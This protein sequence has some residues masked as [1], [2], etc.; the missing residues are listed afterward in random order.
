M[1][2][3]ILSTD[4]DITEFT[5][6]ERIKVQLVNLELKQSSWLKQEQ[7]EFMIFNN[8]QC[9]QK[10]QFKNAGKKKF[11]INLSYLNTS[12]ECQVNYAYNWF[13]GA[14]LMLVIAVVL[15]ISDIRDN[16]N[17]QIFS[18]SLAL[19]NLSGSLTALLI[20]WKKS[21]HRLIFYSHY[22]KA[23]ILEFIHAS[24]DKKAFRTFIEVLTD[25][26]SLANKPHDND[27]KGYLL[28]ELDELRRLK[29]ESV[30]GSTEFNAA[31]QRIVQQPAYK[32]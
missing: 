10:V 15:I 7:R 30:L 12:P 25:K 28:K 9:Y 6:E 23:P 22:G 8:R 2:K 24:P 11:R 14:A 16:Q 3:I 4:E 19:V 26:I 31:L 13:I 5:D 32:A 1:E 20:G 29:N 18:V 21:T 27:M 17:L